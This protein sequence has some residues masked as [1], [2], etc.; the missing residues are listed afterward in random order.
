[1][2]PISLA[3]YGRNAARA[4][5]CVATVVVA[6]CGS[7]DDPMSGY[8]ESPEVTLVSVDIGVEISDTVVATAVVGSVVARTDP[9]STAPLVAEL[10]NPIATGGP[11]VFQVV[12]DEGDWLRVLLPVRPNG[13]AG[14]IRSADV[15][16]SRN[17]YRV[18]IDTTAKSL[19]VSREGNPVIET[20][21]AIGTGE[22]PTPIGSFYLT[23]LL[24]PPDPNGPYGTYAFGLSGFSE[25]L[26]EF[27]GGTG[28]VGI[29]GTNDPSSI[30]SEVSHGCIRVNND[31]MDELASIL[32]L[33]TPVTIRI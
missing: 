32:P 27:N 1:M 19:V 17:L 25:T 14:W 31:V 4:A 21:V 8:R 13:S 23:E 6:G 22:T 24:R 5:A 30:G 12:A 2:N 7:V 20:Q 3:R 26:T 16:L 15:S 29:H 18:D 33:G 28:V 10:D 11:L 9:L